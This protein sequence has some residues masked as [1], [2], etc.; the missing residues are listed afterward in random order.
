MT[1]TLLSQT[2]IPR[3][4]RERANA[5]LT[6]HSH[7]LVK[8]FQLQVLNI[9]PGHA[10]WLQTAQD[11]Q[12]AEFILDALRPQTGG[13]LSQEPC[14]LLFR[15]V[16]E[17]ADEWASVYRGYRRYVGAF[18]HIVLKGTATVAWRTSGRRPQSAQVRPGDVFA[19]D[20]SKLHSVTSRT[21]CV[22]AC[23]VVPRVDIPRWKAPGY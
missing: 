14:I 11:A 5:L 4:V 23:F 3:N 9:H 22:T 19:L 15:D 20:V 13:L 2:R 12:H 17:H 1:F 10:T 18:L 8:N 16:D 21:A 6:A 7:Q